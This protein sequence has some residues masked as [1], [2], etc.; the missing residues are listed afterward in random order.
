MEGNSAEV[1]NRSEIE[2]VIVS[3]QLFSLQRDFA[4]VGFGG[5]L[6]FLNENIIREVGEHSPSRRVDGAVAETVSR[7][8]HSQLTANA[9]LLSE[10]QS[11]ETMNNSD[12]IG[13]DSQFAYLAAA[14]SALAKRNYRDALNR[15]HSGINDDL[16]SEPQ[17]ELGR[18]LKSFSTLLSY[19]DFRLGED[20][21][22][23]WEAQPNEAAEAD[24]RCSFCGKKEK[25]VS[26]IIAGPGVFICDE[27]VRICADTLTGA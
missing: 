8:Q 12:S 16:A 19:L 20:F 5:A 11:G 13:G 2:R 21:G 4:E 18:L 24:I 6:H 17:G 27:C 14:Q 26:R 10:K 1:S 25:E 3:R 22:S 23:Q 7:W 9:K 15:L